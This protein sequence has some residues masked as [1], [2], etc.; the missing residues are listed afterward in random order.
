VDEDPTTHELRQEQAEREE[1]ER[2][3]ADE[4][5]LDADTAEHA[6]RADKAEYLKEKLEDRAASERREGG[7]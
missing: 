4:A 5:H 6:R 1:E 3:D 2:R 7:S